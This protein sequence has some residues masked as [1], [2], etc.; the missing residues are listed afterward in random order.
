[1]DHAARCRARRGASLRD[2]SPR[3]TRA[4]MRA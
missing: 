3:S 4:A 2:G 1:V